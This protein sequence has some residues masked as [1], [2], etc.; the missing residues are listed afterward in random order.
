MIYIQN[1][2]VV[3]FYLGYFFVPPCIFR[4]FGLYLHFIVVSDIEIDF[5]RFTVRNTI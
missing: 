4:V 1:L 3:Q 2:V 5:K